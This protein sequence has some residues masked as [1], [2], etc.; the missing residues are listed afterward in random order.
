MFQV[1]TQDEIYLN[2]N[3]MNQLK[4][5]GAVTIK[6]SRIHGRGVFATCDIPKHSIVTLYPRHMI[7]LDGLIE[8]HMMADDMNF[9]VIDYQM[10]LSENISI[11][12]FPTHTSDPKMLGHMLNDP[13]GNT[14][15]SPYKSHIRQS[16]LKYFTDISYI[17][18]CTCKTDMDVGITY[19]LTLK[20]IKCDEELVMPYGPQYWF[21]HFQRDCEKIFGGPEGL[22]SE[23]R[24]PEIK[25]LITGILI[26]SDFV[27]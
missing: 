17:C 6:N 1:T 18:N 22:E 15:Y 7:I 5:L 21:R 16:I 9:D 13:V 10:K 3:R 26:N 2:K 20:N 24:D 23:L 4:F 8:S 11:V 12:G 27:H 25:K 14:F 19:I